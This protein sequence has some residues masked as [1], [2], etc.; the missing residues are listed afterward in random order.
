MKFVMSVLMVLV[1]IGAPLYASFHPEVPAKSVAYWAVGA[2][3]LI[4]VM[5][6]WQV[7]GNLGA[8]GSSWSLSVALS[9]DDVLHDATGQP[10]IDPQTK[11]P[12]TRTSPSTSRLIAF[13]GMLVIVCMFLGVGY[14]IIL[15]LFN[16]EKVSDNLAGIWSYFLAGATLFAPYAAS[17]IKD[18][19]KK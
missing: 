4:L 19:M 17:Q 2:I 18:M 14:Y 5:V 16:G 15:G 9:E 11:T 8:A 3:N 13:M 7:V 10:V 12:V 1:L 6:L